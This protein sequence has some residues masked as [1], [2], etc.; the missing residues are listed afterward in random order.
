MILYHP[1]AGMVIRA[2]MLP[3]RQ[4]PHPPSY[5]SSRTEE[6][7]TLNVYPTQRDA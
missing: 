3:T 4:F 5:E 7:E 2:P 1:L 6:C